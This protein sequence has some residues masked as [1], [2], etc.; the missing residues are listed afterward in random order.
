MEPILKTIRSVRCLI[1]FDRG[2]DRLC[3]AYE[4][5]I[6]N[7]EAGPGSRTACQGF[8]AGQFPPKTTASYHESN[9]LLCHRRGL[10]ILHHQRGGPSGG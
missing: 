7:T 3:T 4:K 8:T 9:P 5:P 2:S 10:S 6:G 1:V